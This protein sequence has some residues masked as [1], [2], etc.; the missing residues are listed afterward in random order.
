MK[1]RRVGAGT[2]A[3]ALA[4]GIGL[5]ACAQ[6]NTPDEYNTLTEQN[7]LETCTNFY[8]NNTDDSLSI[9]ENT[10]QE[11]VQAPNEEVCRCSYAVF[12][13]PNGD[14]TEGG[15][16]I[17]EAAAETI[18]W[19]GPNFTDLNADLKSNPQEAWDALPQDPF[20]DGLT[21]CAE[22]GGGSTTTTTAEDGSTTTTAAGSATDGTDADESTTTT[23]G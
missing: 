7:F 16:P 20:K 4:L 19:T 1:R 21:D 8:F 9:T 22:G 14:G 23:A 12:T 15:M 3:V 6:G 5:G 13:G 2:A 11:D 10:V 17:N 18:G